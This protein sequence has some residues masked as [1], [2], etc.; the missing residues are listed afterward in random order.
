M[1]LAT[2]RTCSG[3]GPQPGGRWSWAEV[4][5]LWTQQHLH[6]RKWPASLPFCQQLIAS[7]I[8]NIRLTTSLPSF[9][10]D[11]E[12]A[13]AT[14]DPVPE[15]QIYRAEPS[16]PPAPLRSARPRRL[17]ARSTPRRN[18]P[19]I[20]QSYQRDGIFHFPCWPDSQGIGRLLATKGDQRSWKQRLSS[21]AKTLEQAF[22]GD[23][24]HRSADFH[25]LRSQS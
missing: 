18:W 20:A 1:R 22:C 15:R 7:Y 3:R 8:V 25:L 5:G 24:V 17:W 12:S 16:C 19:G 9:G 23:G 4:D 13:A 11:S 14:P 10:T 21:A 2:T 6:A